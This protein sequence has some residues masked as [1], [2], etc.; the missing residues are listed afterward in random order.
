MYYV[1]TGD[2][3]AREAAI[4]NAAYIFRDSPKNWTGWWGSRIPGWGI[5][6]LISLYT[7]I[8]NPTYLNEACLGVYRYEEVELAGG[9]NGYVLSPGSNDTQGWMENMMTSSSLNTS[10]T[11]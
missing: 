7:Y 1:T 4:E 6:N 8:G 3:A 11:P 5:D 10:P 2:E 9:G